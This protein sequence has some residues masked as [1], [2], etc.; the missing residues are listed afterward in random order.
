MVTWNEFNYELKDNE[1]VSMAFQAS[2]PP[3]EET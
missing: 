1:K 2:F 3:D